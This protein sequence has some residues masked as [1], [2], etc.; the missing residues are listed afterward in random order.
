MERQMTFLREFRQALLSSSLYSTARAC[1]ISLVFALLAINCGP[2]PKGQYDIPDTINDTASNETTT[3]PTAEK[4][5]LPESAT[6]DLQKM[7]YITDAFKVPPRVRSRRPLDDFQLKMRERRQHSA[8]VTNC[9]FDVLKSFVAKEWAPIVMV[10]LQERTPVILSVTQYDNRANVVHLHNPANLN[11][12]QLTY[13]E[14]ETAW[15]KDARKRCL[16]I[17]PQQLTET[18][19]KKALGQYLSTETFQEISVRS[20]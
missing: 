8:I 20:Y 1:V 14:F 13:E 4:G 15:A 18:D 9:T 6:I 5:S 7:P 10:Q 11:K 2:V 12:R 3:Q 16:L 17:T 19:V